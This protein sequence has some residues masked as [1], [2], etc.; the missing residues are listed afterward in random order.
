M[1]KKLLITFIIGSMALNVGCFGKDKAAK[2]TNSET[3]EITSE[4]NENASENTE[5]NSDT[6]ENEELLQFSEMKQGEEIAIVKTNYGDIKIRFFKEKAPKAV[7]NFLTHAKN[8][9]YN[10]VKFHRIIKDFMI[11]SGDPKGDGT[12]GESIYDGTP[13]E[14]E[15]SSNLRHFRGALSMAN[16]GPNTNG[17]Q[18]FIVQ[19]SKIDETGKKEL[20]EFINTQE[21]E[22][23]PEI[24]IKD[25]FPKNVCEKYLEI[26]GSPSLDTQYSVFGQVF[27]GMDIVDK[28]A[29]VEVKDSGNGEVSSPVKDVIIESIEVTKYK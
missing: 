28:I 29:N 14:N 15:V 9:Y 10:N 26:G 6:Q 27:E 4:A 5:S 3:T 20:E 22:V 7:E 1:K 23:T 24:K 12:G 19:N 25:I 21:E 8:G 2:D 18:F 11:Q 16:A 17:S 13:F